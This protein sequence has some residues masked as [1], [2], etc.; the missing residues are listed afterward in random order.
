MEQATRPDHG[1][2]LN[3]IDVIT[4][5]FAVTSVVS[6]VTAGK[7]M[8]VSGFVLPASA[9]IFPL[10]YIFGD[11][12]TEVYGFS[13]SRRVI[14][15]GFA[16]SVTASLIFGAVSIVPSPPWFESALAYKT[17][18]GQVP[19]IA[20][21]G[22]LAFFLGEMSN[23]AILSILKKVTKGR[24]LWLRALLSTMVGELVDT[25]IF[26][27]IAFYSVFSPPQMIK[28]ILTL[29]CWKVAVEAILLPATY[30]ACKALKKAE[31]VDVYDFGV[32]YNPFGFREQ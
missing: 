6:G 5:A 17:V 9:I 22:W 14:W 25:A 11:I 4:A 19:L 24:G 27:S 29:Y 21:A 2:R 10:A 28:T 13:R 31:G 26:L 12:L 20:V 1:R 8:I 3:Y 7:L 23:S 30:A 32:T 15:I 18:L 16:C